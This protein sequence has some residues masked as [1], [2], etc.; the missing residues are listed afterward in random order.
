MGL[1]R[2]LILN[3]CVLS[4]NVTGQLSVPTADILNS[5]S[6]I[7]ITKG[8]TV[9]DIRWS[10]SLSTNNKLTRAVIDEIKYID[11][12]WDTPE[13]RASNGNIFFNYALKP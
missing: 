3:E 8:K 2:Q 11:T 1:V 4:N 10:V 7:I 6:K 13:V 5:T 12:V 9:F